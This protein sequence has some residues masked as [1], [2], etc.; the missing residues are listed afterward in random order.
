[1]TYSSN[2][3]SKSLLTRRKFVAKS[4]MAAATFTFLKPTL[5]RGSKQN[6]KIEVGII[7]LG[8]RGSIIS[9]KLAAHEGYALVAAADYNSNFFGYD[10][11]LLPK[12]LCLLLEVLRLFS[13]R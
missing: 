4:S 12:K 5:I 6:S 11:H 2:K 13:G 10:L 1:M 3:T 9:Q 7:G 8:G